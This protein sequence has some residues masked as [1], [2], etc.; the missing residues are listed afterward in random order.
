MVS[1]ESF[2]AII[3][4]LEDRYDKTIPDIDKEIWFEYFNQ[5]L[6]EEELYKAYALATVQLNFIPTPEWLV[7]SVKGS[8]ST[9]ANQ[10]WQKIV[11]NAPDRV[12]TPL[13]ISARGRR[14]L[15]L[16]GGLSAVRD[17]EVQFLDAKRKSFVELW[18]E[19][20]IE[21]ESLVQ[22]RGGNLKALPPAKVDYVAMMKAVSALPDFIGFSKVK[23]QELVDE[24]L[25]IGKHEFEQKYTELYFAEWLRCL[26]RYHAPLYKQIIRDVN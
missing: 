11:D 20:D 10:E 8:E 18:K 1:Q 19:K 2:V 14:A 24:F 16:I 4:A 25:K 26:E 3:S 7:S 5:T 9:I 6:T 17:C 23:H 21:V 12:K 13:E 22:I 15:K